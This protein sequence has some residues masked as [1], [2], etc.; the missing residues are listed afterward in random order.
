MKIPLFVIHVRNDGMLD[1]DIGRN[2][3]FL[4]QRSQLI[5]PQ[6]MLKLNQ[7]IPYLSI[8]S[9]TLQRI[10]STRTTDKS[11]FVDVTPAKER[12]T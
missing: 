4:G 6:Y 1:V 8:G 5:K 11:E 2:C 3:D 9:Q 7:S 10:K 12:A